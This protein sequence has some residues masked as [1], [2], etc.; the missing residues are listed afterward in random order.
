MRNPGRF[1]RCWESVYKQLVR[2]EKVPEFRTRR[3]VFNSVSYFLGLFGFVCY[4]KAGSHAWE[5]YA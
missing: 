2:S 3:L 4:C 5:T 1:E